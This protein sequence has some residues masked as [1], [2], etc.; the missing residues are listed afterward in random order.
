MRKFSSAAK[1]YLFAE[2]RGSVLR[3]SVG[4]AFLNDR[5]ELV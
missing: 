5:I 2:Q 4:C 3:G 1:R